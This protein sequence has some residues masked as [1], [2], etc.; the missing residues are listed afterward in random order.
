MT[1]TTEPFIPR[2]DDAVATWLAMRIKAARED[3]AKEVVTQLS[4]ALAEYCYVADRQEPLPATSD[5]AR[6]LAVHASDWFQA[7]NAVRE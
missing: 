2:R 3:V 7:S 6:M 5:D 1:T 4:R